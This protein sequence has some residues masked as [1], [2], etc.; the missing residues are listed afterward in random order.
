[1]FCKISCYSKVVSSG[2]KFERR[3]SGRLDF[4]LC[5]RNGCF[6][7]LRMRLSGFGCHSCE[8]RCGALSYVMWLGERAVF[9][10]TGKQ[11]LC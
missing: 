2:R 10:Q 7:I 3:T 1:M 4:S 6:M 9:H 8:K 5:I 11:K